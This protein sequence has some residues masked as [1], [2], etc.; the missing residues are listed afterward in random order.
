MWITQDRLLLVSLLVLGP[1]FVFQVGAQPRFTDVTEEAIPLPLFESVGMSFGDYN[2]DGWPDLFIAESLNFVYDGGDRVVLLHNSG[3]GRFVRR[4]AALPAG[5]LHFDPKYL[6]GETFG[7]AVFGDYDNDGDED[8]YLPLGSGW[9]HRPTRNALLRNDG[10]IFTDVSQEAGLSQEIASRTALWLDYDRDGYIDL[11]VTNA[12]GVLVDFFATEP[13]NRDLAVMNRLYRN[14]RDGTFSD[15]SDPEFAVARGDIV[16]PDLDDDGWPDLYVGLNGPN[17]L[18]LNDSQGG[19][20]EGP[21]GDLADPGAVNG[22][23]I[24]DIDNDGR[25]DLF[26]PSAASLIPDVPFRSLLLLNRGGGQFL[27]I[28]EDAGLGVLTDIPIYRAILADLD[29]DGDLDLATGSPAF[30]FLNN[31]A[32]GFSEATVN[33]G[34]PTEFNALPGIVAGDY[35]RDGCLDLVYGST[36]TISNQ[37]GGLYRNTCNDNH[38]LRIELVGTQSNRRGLGAR[39]RIR[40]GPVQQTRELLGGSGFFQT[41]AAAHFGLGPHPQVDTLEVRWPSG[42]IDLHT[43]LPVDKPLRLFEGEACYH[44]AEPVRWTHSL[45]DTIE[46]G[47]TLEWEARVQPTLY[48]PEANIE[49]VTADLSAWGGDKAVALVPENEGTYRLIPGSGIVEGVPGSREVAVRIEQNSAYGP[50]WTQLVHPIEVVPMGPIEPVSLYGEG[51]DWEIGGHVE[52]W[53][54]LVPEIEVLQ[55]GRV[56]VASSSAGPVFRGRTALAVEVGSLAVVPTE[57]WRVSFRASTPVANYRTLRLA[58]HPGTAQPDD[59]PILQVFVNGLHLSTA[60]LN[61]EPIFPFIN[62]MTRT[63]LDMRFPAWN[64]IEF[65]LNFPGLEGPIESVSLVGGFTGTFYFDEIQLLPEAR[66]ALATSVIETHNSPVPESF[67]LAQSFPNPF[68]AG[69]TIRF[70]L[71]TAGPVELA[72][73]NLA[74]QKVTTLLLGPRQAG[75]YS[76]QW[77]GKNDNGRSLASGVYLYK[78]QAGGQA[79]T[80]K[81]LLLR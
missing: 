32:G 79:E 75:Q 7:A 60:L 47:E 81:L 15:V 37:F 66:P 74:G 62:F 8:L 19:F 30:I 52:I 59:I 71:P 13:E 35:D 26:Q 50:T 80:R 10:G 46:V 36:T 21:A 51:T 70:T 49:Q 44:I 57:A 76:L 77:D 42:Q 22:V 61:P 78:L 9:L 53:D 14:N 3:Q 64:V 28:T 41:E 33:A 67:E 69:T 56:K 4:S 18:F 23:A 63:V 5:L 12:A 73:F 24:G 72:V 29:N 17:R 34:L 2:N 48:A 25:L 40:T 58:F 45:P 68:N 1:L 39:I 6:H 65:P 31:G 27:D 55:D 43:G 20:R 54:A 38:Y 11:Y 16:A